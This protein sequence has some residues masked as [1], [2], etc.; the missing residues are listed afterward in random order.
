MTA[1]HPAADLFPMLPE[2]ALDSLAA[3]IKGRGLLH[4]LV[5]LPDGTLLDGRNRA[6]ACR[7]AGVTPTTTVYTGDDP[8]GYVMSVNLERRHLNEDERGFLAVQLLPMLEEQA[9]LRMLA[10]KPVNPTANWPE[11]SRTERESVAEAARTV[12][13]APRRVKRAKRISEQA[14]DLIPEVIAGRM[15]MSKAETKAKERAA[16]ISDADA[17][18]WFTPPWVF[19]SMAPRVTF[20]LDVCAPRNAA[21]RT[22]PAVNY[23]TED[24]DGLAQP[25]EG[26][27]WCNPPYSQPETWADRMIGHGNGVLL[28]HMPNNAK[29]MVR[30]QLAATSIRPIQSMHFVR[31][32]GQEQRPGYSLMLLAYGDDAAYLIESVSGPMVWPLLKVAGP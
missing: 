13:V 20:D 1:V 4:P 27:V 9:R 7:R 17:D 19:D 3:D 8:V 29:W 31:P 24:D 2:D 10:G 28:V 26:L 6:E 16:G 14:P 22:V 30:A 25:W 32:N 23:F 5:V 21:H 15:S 11:G 12:N 18:A